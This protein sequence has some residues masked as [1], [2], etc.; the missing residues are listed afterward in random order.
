MSSTS[1]PHLD[2]EGYKMGYMRSQ[3]MS[4]EEEKVNFKTERVKTGNIT[5]IKILP[6]NP[7]STMLMLKIPK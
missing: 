2:Q 4:H 6:G 5:I 3:F 1:K 7:D